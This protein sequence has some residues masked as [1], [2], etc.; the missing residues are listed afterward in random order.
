MLFGISAL[1]GANSKIKGYP[2]LEKEYSD[3][4][5]HDGVLSCS[6]SAGAAI[7]STKP[8][9]FHQDSSYLPTEDMPDYLALVAIKP[10]R[11]KIPTHL[12]PTRIVAERLNDKTDACLRN[13]SNFAGNEAGN[14][15]GPPQSKTSGNVPLSNC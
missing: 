1:L 7:S 13:A 9:D 14:D 11:A 12:L 2:D 10:G 3:P 4:Y 15:A 5:V 8:Q 6:T